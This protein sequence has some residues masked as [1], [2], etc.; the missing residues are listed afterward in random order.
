MACSLGAVVTLLFMTSLMLDIFCLTHQFSVT[1][2]RQCIGMLDI[3][4]K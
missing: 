1:V 4:G 2:Y 3:Y